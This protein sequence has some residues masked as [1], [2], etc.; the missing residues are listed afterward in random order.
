M[1]DCEP[2]EATVVNNDLVND[3]GPPPLEDPS[4]SSDDEERPTATA[5]HKMSNQALQVVGPKLA[6]LSRHSANFFM[7]QLIDYIWK[8]Y[9]LPLSIESQGRLLTHPHASLYT[10]PGTTGIMRG[11]GPREETTVEAHS[12]AFTR[13]E[14]DA[15]QGGRV[16]PGDVMGDHQ[17]D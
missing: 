3:T 9:N 14:H 8:R 11:E 10:P 13:Q 17:D 6:G 4:D 15:H 16:D 12:D 2:Q 7:H 5:G 1:S